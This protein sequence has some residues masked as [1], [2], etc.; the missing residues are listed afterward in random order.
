[1]IEFLKKIP[2]L[3][4]LS[5]DDLGRLT[6]MIEVV[7]LPAGAQL[8]A[9]GSP[10]DRAYI[11]KEGQIDIRT[12][13]ASG[14]HLLAIRQAGEVIGEMALLD[15]APR[16]ASAWAKTD[17]ILLALGQAQFSHLL[18]T[19]PAATRTIL[20]LLLPRWRATEAALRQRNAELELREAERQR[21]QQVQI[22]LYRIAEAA[23]SVEQMA[24]FYAAIHHIVGGLMYAN[25][26]FIALYD[27]TRRVVKFP[28]YMDQVD[29]DVPDPRRWEKLGLGWAKGLTAY[30]LRTGQPLLVTPTKFEALLQQ[31]EIEAVGVPPID[32]LGIPLKTGGR[33]LGVLVVQSYSEASRYS[34]K[35]VELLTYVAQHIAAALE[36]ARLQTETRER[37]AELTIINSVGQALAKQLNL[38]AIIDLVGDNIREIFAAHTTYIALY[39]P[40]NQ[41]IHWPY[42]VKNGQRHQ[43]KADRFGV[44]LTSK[45]IETGQPSIFDTAAEQL[46]LGDLA[47]PL[48]PA[49]QV[50]SESY[51]AVPI[52]VGEGIVTG[53]VS[54]Q[55]DE[56]YVYDEGSVRL[57]STITASMGVALE[58]A[59][60]FDETNRLLIE[61]RQRSAELATVN[62]ISQ[63]LSTELE[64]DTL[65]ELIG[66]QIRQIFAADIVYLALLDPHTNLIHF[67]Y[68][69]EA[70]QRRLDEPLPFGQGL[71]SKIIQLRQP[72]LLNQE[73]DYAAIPVAR[74][75][76]RSKSYLGVPILAGDQA[77]GAISVQSTQK[78]G[79]FDQADLRLLSTIAANVGAALHNARLYQETQRR[80]EE[81]A[82]LAQV[83]R[84]LT[85]ILDLPALLERIAAH[86]CKLLTSDTSA[87][88]LL[89]ADGQTLHLIAAAGDVADTT[90]AFKPKMGQG[91]VGGV[92][93]SGLP[94]KVDD[95]L[96]D[97]RHA[98]VPG[99]LALSGQKL[100][101]APLAS[102][103]RVIG[104]MTVQRN[105]QQP[106]FNQADLNFLVALSRQAAIGIE[107]AWLFSEAQEARA[108][109]E[110]A[111]RAKSTF[112]ANM[113]HELRTP[114]NAI[115]GFTRIVRRKA[116]GVLS[117][118]QVGNLDKVLVSAEHLLGLINTVLDIAKIEAGR[119]EVQ[120]TIFDLNNLVTTCTATAQPL[121]RPGV[122]LA[123][124]LVPALPPLYSDPDKAKQILLNLLSN[125]AKFT[126]T[127]VIT[128][129]VEPSISRMSAE[130]GD[131][132]TSPHLFALSP[133]S[134]IIRV[135]D[136]GIG[137][138]TEALGRIF[139]EFQ[140]AD[141]STTRQYGGTGLGLSISR[142][143][144]HLLGGDLTVTSTVGVG[145]TFTLTLPLRYDGAK[146]EKN[147]PYL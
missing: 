44:G 11:I 126:H 23:A 52:L 42:Y 89:E 2:L 53:V 51:L 124:N 13:S 18:D 39:D 29:L 76:T 65:I 73:Q 45:V 28:Y 97:P 6:Q 84:E 107:N 108:A 101:L 56:P 136:T 133:S 40:K 4:D 17:S 92:A 3:A 32:W 143:L 60:L 106:V 61:T 12:S 64:L 105:P 48:S 100:L 142:K 36:R 99:G 26:F 135:S 16:S 86:S 9:E 14:E 104:V 98:Q 147:S 118:K 131:G 55:N 78:E 137:I 24:E 47:T 138:S 82:A 21:T 129:S 121:L 114:L 19:S 38:Q 139:E 30:V 128:V 130:P 119:T 31:G 77:I 8:F 54:V 140:Q 57:L 115:I 34:Y 10:G 90:R 35:D 79:R 127:G 116:D 63:A 50:R 132:V 120:P 87:I 88:Y 91:I 146:V 74:V 58:N 33:T 20:H 46:S 93:Q 110:Q 111:N 67:P 122:T 113:S 81:M 22:A 117:E 68:Y 75:G 141:T 1:M 37:M 80:A 27:E 43:L 49:E 69:Q 85:A 103:E 96:S 7:H 109:A 95:V 94:E 71:T 134:V 62:N 72:L 70:G 144:A 145:S 41:L 112:L 59:R 102:R 83:G 125:A 15:D 5:P 25:N 123:A 66:E